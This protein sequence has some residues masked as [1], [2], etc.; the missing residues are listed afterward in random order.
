MEE[1]KNQGGLSLVQILLVV[2]IF[3]V[4]ISIAIPSMYQLQT[5][6]RIDSVAAEIG[7]NLR[8]A[9]TKAMT[10]YQNS[11][12][13]IKFNTNSYVIFSGETCD[14]RNQVEDENFIISNSINMVNDFND[15]ILFSQ[16]TGVPSVIGTIILSNIT[17]E[18]YEIIINAEGAVSY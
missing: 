8:R 11:D 17:S 16:Y 1:I 2:A 13:G 18:E 3:L 14:T 9:Q 12:W 5:G 10:G 15:E 7:Q 4:I 6:V